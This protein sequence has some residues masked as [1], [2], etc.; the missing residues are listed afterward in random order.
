M[1]KSWLTLILLSAILGLAACGTPGTV[2]LPPATTPAQNGTTPPATPAT[3]GE[4]SD[5]FDGWWEEYRRPFTLDSSAYPAFYRGAYGSRLDELRG[6]LLGAAG[7]RQAGFDSVMLG[8]DVVFDPAT[9]EAKS[10]GDDVF[11]FYLQALKREGFRIILIPNPMHPN[12]DMGLGYEWEDYD[13]AAGYHRSY[14]LIHRLDDA[15]VKWAALAE[16][17]GVEGFAPCNEPYKLVRDY[18]DASRWL[19]EIQPRIREVY[20]GPLWAVDTMHDIGPG[21]SIPYPYDY[22][23]YNRIL[24]GPPAGWKDIDPWEEMFRLYIEQGSQ[25]V[26]DYDL[27]GFGLYECG[28]YTGGIWYEDG[29]AVW[30]QVMSQAQAGEIAA[31]MVRQANGVASACFPRV[32]TGWID[33]GTPAFDIVSDWYLNL[34]GIITPLEAGV[35]TYD[36]LIEI[37]QRLA[38]EDY[39]DIFQ[40]TE[41]TDTHQS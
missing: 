25:Y 33:P 40:I 24:C 14:E 23:G 10:L 11:L 19:Q 12:L 21:R 29:L 26:A 38:G 17:Y 27:E 9:G 28:A 35:W 4:P 16:E 20:H 41:I 18:T 2:T 31:A 39:E 22:T 8:V 32:S 3:T 34:G 6:Y 37:E 7:L 15:V 30:D 13:P 36:E 5:P 1:R